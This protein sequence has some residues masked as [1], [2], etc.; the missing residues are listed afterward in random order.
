[1]V[2]VKTQKIRL[3]LTRRWNLRVRSPRELYWKLHE[4]LESERWE[5]KYEP[6]Q[7]KDDAISGS[8]LFSDELKG[9]HDSHP[10]WRIL[11]G[12]LL[13]LT[14]I[15]IPVGLCFFRKQ[16]V[17]ITIEVEGESY[18]ARGAEVLTT[19][20]KEMLD[21]ISDCRVTLKLNAGKVVKRKKTGEEII[22]PTKSKRKTQELDRKVTV[23]KRKMDK[24]ILPNIMLPE[25]QV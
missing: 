1:M 5:H 15:L 19:Q 4:F 20:E 17:E 10:W 18:R 16:R 14:I 11:V 25:L 3:P 23:L 2:D 6:L 24:E 12:I 21:V 7:P 22:K 8:A 9:R 13:C